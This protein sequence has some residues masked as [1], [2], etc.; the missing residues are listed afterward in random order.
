[1]TQLQRSQNDR[2][3]HE[4]GTSGSGVD[5]NIATKNDSSNEA[6]AVAFEKWLSTK[7]N[8]TEGNDDGWGESFSSAQWHRFIIERVTSEQQQFPQDAISLIPRLPPQPEQLS[9]H[10]AASGGRSA[11][12]GAS[13]LTQTSTPQ[14]T[15]MP[16]SNLGNTAE[17]HT[18]FASAPWS[19]S[20]PTGFGPQS[21]SQLFTPALRNSGIGSVTGDGV[22]AN[23][24]SQDQASHS[25][26]PIQDV[27]S[28]SS[29]PGLHHSATPAMMG[30]F[31]S[32]HLQRSAS[33]VPVQHDLLPVGSTN[34]TSLFGMNRLH[35]NAALAPVIF[36]AANQLN[37][38]DGLLPFKGMDSLPPITGHRQHLQVPHPQGKVSDQTALH[39]SEQQMKHELWAQHYEQPHT[40]SLQKLFIQ[41]ERERECR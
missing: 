8:G 34:P 7:I 9:S 22:M 36:P 26:P 17:P 28:R 14:K 12:T 40:Q 18:L 33:T 32:N 38:R 23:T 35:S 4:I 29:I 24:P 11:Q 2:G 16:C 3:L 1:M 41:C 10:S 5:E 25:N 21:V 15:A 30:S 31:L 37:S 39:I 20:L 27:Q 19:S 13:M 6:W